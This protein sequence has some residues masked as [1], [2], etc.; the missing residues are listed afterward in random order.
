[1]AGKGIK[2]IKPLEISPKKLAREE[3]NLSK[4]IKE[5]KLF[6]TQR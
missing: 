6:S 1:M 5:K 2:L 4:F 3:W